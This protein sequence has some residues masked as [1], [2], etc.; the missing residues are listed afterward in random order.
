MYFGQWGDICSVCPA[1]SCLYT[2]QVK[3]ITFVIL[4]WACKICRKFEVVFAS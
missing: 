3:V 1:L 4:A 2:G